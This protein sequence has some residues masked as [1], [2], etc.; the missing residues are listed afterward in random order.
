MKFWIESIQTM[1]KRSTKSRLNRPPPASSKPRRAAEFS[2][3]A[4]GPRAPVRPF[5]PLIIHLPASRYP[6]QGLVDSGADY[7]IFPHH[8]AATFGIDLAEC[9]D[10][11]C[12]TAGG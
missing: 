9:R 5:L 3:R 7:S 10:E 11:P 12:T 6:V 2:Y 4:S 1:S 8:W